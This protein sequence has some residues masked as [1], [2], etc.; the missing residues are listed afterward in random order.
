VLDGE[1]SVLKA[2][3]RHGDE[4]RVPDIQ[5]ELPGTSERQTR[6][7]LLSLSKKGHVVAQRGRGCYSLT[8]QG[9]A[10]LLAELTEHE[11][12]SAL[13]VAERQKKSF[14]L[15][16]VVEAL[17]GGG[18]LAT[19]LAIQGC[20]AEGNTVG[21]ALENLED[22]AAVLLRLQNETGLPMPSGLDEFRPERTL[23]AQLVVPFPR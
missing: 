18:Y 6:S 3:A 12:E 23:K 4:A 8:H 10:R 9:K 15:P 7:R 21:E 13:L 16:V 19:C 5:A 1:L 17:D 20:L 22:V 11:P 2:I 14:V